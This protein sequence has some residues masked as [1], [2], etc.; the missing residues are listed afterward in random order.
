MRGRVDSERIDADEDAGGVV[1]TAASEGVGD[2]GAE[3]EG[4][5]ATF[6]KATGE[7]R[8]V[9][10][11]AD[12]IGAD[13]NLVSGL[14]RVNADLDFER[15]GLADATR[16][17][18]AVAIL[19]LDHFAAG[20]AQQNLV[21]DRIVHGELEEAVGAEKVAARV[22]HVGDMEA[23]AHDGGDAEG[24]AETAIGGEAGAEVEHTIVGGAE[25]GG[26]VEGLAAIGGVASGLHQGGDGGLGGLGAAGQAADAIGDGV[27]V[28]VLGAE[29]AVL[30]FGADVT[31]VG[32]GCGGG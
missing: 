28:E 16:E 7:L 29:Q 15:H 14:K 13:E 6:A 8:V 21:L 26:Q 19:E 18:V 12:A 4:G 9:E 2:K 3:H 10:H 23:V 11:P 30:V 1:R 25:G 31:D 17:G 27:K 24:G 5:R 22:A 32:L 20:A